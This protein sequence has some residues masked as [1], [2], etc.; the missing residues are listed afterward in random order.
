MPIY[1]IFKQIEI[2]GKQITSGQ[3]V[4]FLGM[5]LDEKLKW[6]PQAEHINEMN[7]TKKILSFLSGRWCG[8]TLRSLIT[9]YKGLIQPM[10]EYGPF[11]IT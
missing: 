8:A 5:Y 9:L 3:Q 10:V 1:N 4:K 7:Q 6:V 11:L 2:N